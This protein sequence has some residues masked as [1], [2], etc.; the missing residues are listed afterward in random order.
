[1]SKE[2][3]KENASGEAASKK[4]PGASR[5]VRIKRTYINAEPLPTGEGAA[6]VEL[7][8]S[9]DTGAIAGEKRDSLPFR[10]GF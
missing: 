10:G 2:I 8:I 1:M 6:G 9:S 5:F 4:A 3:A 7:D